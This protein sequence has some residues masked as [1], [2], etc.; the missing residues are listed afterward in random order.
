MF[1]SLS[2][3]TFWF[4]YHIYTWRWLTVKSTFLCIS[5]LACRWNTI[6]KFFT[7]FLCKFNSRSGNSFNWIS[8]TIIT[9]HLICSVWIQRILQ[10]W[11]LTYTSFLNIYVKHHVM[12]FVSI[13]KVWWITSIVTKIITTWGVKLK[14]R[15][16]TS[17]ILRSNFY[18]C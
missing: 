11:I 5:V 8:Q 9:W 13:T 15:I 10:R 14:I 16:I 17:I 1:Y 3:K 6:I 12:T 2:H 4:S 18:I 7:Y